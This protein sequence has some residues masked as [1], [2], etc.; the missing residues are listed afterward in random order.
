MSR[1]MGILPASMEDKFLPPFKSYEPMG[2]HEF[3]I[4]IIYISNIF[5][6]HFKL[7]VFMDQIAP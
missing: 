3:G 2:L 4:Y 1:R 7:L 6:I 5:L